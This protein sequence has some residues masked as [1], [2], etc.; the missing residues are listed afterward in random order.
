MEI[1]NVKTHDMAQCTCCDWD[2]DGIVDSGNMTNKC[3][4]HANK[5]GHQVQR[6][7]GRVIHYNPR[8]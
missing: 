2:A 7:I 4:G 6:D 8:A 3:Q 5:T 1:K